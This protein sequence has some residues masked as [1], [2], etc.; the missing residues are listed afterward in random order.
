MVE[1][2]IS[3]P[4]EIIQPINSEQ[5]NNIYYSLVIIFFVIGLLLNTLFPGVLAGIGRHNHQR[6]KKIIRERHPIDGEVLQG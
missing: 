5:V 3:H 2:N 4:L 1:S 6:L